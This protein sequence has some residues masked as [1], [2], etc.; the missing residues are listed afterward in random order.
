MTSVKCER[1]R[2]GEERGE[3]GGGRAGRGE[4][5]KEEIIR[6]MWLERKREGG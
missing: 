6:A 4:V 3:G 5:K 1:E 2:R